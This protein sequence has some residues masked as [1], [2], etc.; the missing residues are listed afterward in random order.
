[1]Q[2]QMLDMIPKRSGLCLGWTLAPDVHP[3]I[4]G[5][6]L[7]PDPHNPLQIPQQEETKSVG[8]WLVFR[9]GAGDE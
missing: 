5:W 4:Q 9:G 6:G 3:H 8:E 7:L 1:M 2:I